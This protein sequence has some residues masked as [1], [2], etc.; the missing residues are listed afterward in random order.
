M[1]PGKRAHATEGGFSAA[2]TIPSRPCHFDRSDVQPD[3][4][5][6]PRENPRLFAYLRRQP[7]KNPMPSMIAITPKGI[8]LLPEPESAAAAAR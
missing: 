6:L 7:M 4:F 8:H 5:I 2:C 3:G 1:Q